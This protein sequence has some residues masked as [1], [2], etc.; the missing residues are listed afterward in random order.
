[1]SILEATLCQEKELWEFRV[2]CECDLGL[3]EGSL[4]YFFERNR[5]IAK[6]VRSSIYG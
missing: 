3:I 5:Q 6:I 4:L 2:N 1:M